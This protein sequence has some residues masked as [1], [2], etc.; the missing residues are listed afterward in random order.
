MPTG[1]TLDRFAQLFAA[2]NESI[3]SQSLPAIPT[4]GI[5]FLI[6]AVVAAIAVLMDAVAIWLRAPALAGVPLLAVVVAP[7]FILASLADGL[8]FE[9][10]AVAYLLILVARGRRIQPA[11]AVSAGVLA[12]LGALAVPSALPSVTA[13]RHDGIRDRRARRDDQPDRQPRR[14]PAPIRL[15][16]RAEL[17]HDLVDGE[18][19]R[20]TTLDSFQGQQWAPA[21][22]RLSA[23]NTV[24]SIGAPAG[25][26]EWRQG[27]NRVDH[28]PGRRGDEPLAARALSSPVDQRAHGRVGVQPGT[29]TVRSNTTTMQGQHYSVASLNVQPT[30]QQMES[31][32][33]RRTT[34]W[35]GSPRVSTPSSP[36]PRERS[37][38]TPRPTSTRRLRC[39]TGSAGAR[40]PTRPRPPRPPD[41]TAR[42]SMS[43]CRSSRPRAGTACTSPPPWRSWRARS[44]SPSRVAVGFLPGRVTHPGNGSVA[45]FQVSSTDLH[46]WPELYFAGVGWVR[47]E[48]T[49]GKGFEP[50]FPQ[51]PAAAA[52]VLPDSTSA[53]GADR[54]RDEVPRS[55][56]PTCRSRPRRPRPRRFSPRRRRSPTVSYGALGVL[57]LLLLAAA[58]TVARIG[59]RRGTTRQDPPR[60]RSGGVVVAGTA[61]HRAGPRGRCQRLL[62]TRGVRRA[63][64]RVPCTRA[65]ANRGRGPGPRG[66][67]VAR[68]GRGVRRAGLPLQRRAHGRAAHDRASRHPSG[69]PAREIASSPR[70]CRRRSSTACSARTAAQA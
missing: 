6:C 42:A 61:R 21:T 41:S 56:R 9:L 32:G 40:S 57:A 62:D 4:T 37:S 69:D 52:P 12:V 54:N 26:D 55:G 45:V 43:S 36:R 24:K 7:S 30:R 53:A 48:P 44:A 25:A 60:R 20:L 70:S 2:A 38:A 1:A 34:R 16:A 65:R 29:L 5:Q 50:R 58:P 23:A 14:R 67:A 22:P 46:A 33:S 64:R 39:R 11:V 3:A 35:P 66:A 68:G 17:H 8:T 18:Y 51:A 15:D 13:G 31:A 19:L 47:F 49:P 10:T 27:R 28:D 63:A 59:I